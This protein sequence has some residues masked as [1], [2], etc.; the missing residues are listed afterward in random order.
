M[1]TNKQQEIFKKNDI[2]SLTTCNKELEPRSIFV[3]VNKVEKDKIIITDNEMKI[4]SENIKNNSKV[5][6]LAF[7]KDFSSVLKIN[8]I[9][10]Y[11]TSG[12]EYDFIKN[13]DGNKDYNKTGVIIIQITKVE[14][15]N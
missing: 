10:E 4:S 6:I 8:G 15:I 2:V 11:K 13:L 5:F 3:A 12:E 1:L 14:K 7:E 9:A